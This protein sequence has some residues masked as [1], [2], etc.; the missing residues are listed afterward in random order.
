MLGIVQSLIRLDRR[1]IHRESIVYET[2]VAFF[3]MQADL[4]DRFV[5]VVLSKIRKTKLDDRTTNAIFRR[6]LKLASRGIQASHRAS[7]VDTT[8]AS[9]SLPAMKSADERIMP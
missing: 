1:L 2:L 3:A 7:L 5:E 9:R 4:Y 8:P 6:I